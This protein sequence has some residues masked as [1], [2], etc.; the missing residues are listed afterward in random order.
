MND[1]FEKSIYTLEL[2][3]VL[4]LLAGEA[5]TEIVTEAD[6]VIY[7]KKNAPQEPV[8]I[9]PGDITGDGKLNAMDI[10]TVSR[11]FAGV[12]SPTDAQLLAGD[13]DGNGRLDGMDLNRI[14]RMIAGT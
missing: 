6:I 2:P 14:A 3:R 11:I 4:K 13:I 12:L 1:L 9:V 8:V 10:N 7:G 5:V